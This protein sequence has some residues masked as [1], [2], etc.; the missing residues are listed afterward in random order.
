MN[1]ATPIVTGLHAA[2]VAVKGE[3]HR[4]QKAGDNTFDNY[5]FTSIDD[6]KDHVRPLLAKHG[7][8]LSISETSFKTIAQ[9][10]SKG[11]EKTHCEIGYEAWL[12]H[13]DGTE[14]KPVKSTVMLPYTGAQTT[15]IAE[16]YAIKKWAKSQLLASSG[17]ST[18][19]ADTRG[20]DE[21]VE[22]LS[23][24]EANPIFEALQKE[25][26]EIALERN[27]GSLMQWSTDNRS[28]YMSMPPD[29]RKYIKEEYSRTLTEIMA[30]EKLDGKQ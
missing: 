15:G 20:Q 18:E 22:V 6:F 17:D 19:E 13:Q 23:R 11:E 5:H 8:Y 12:T 2:I 25:L 27:S 21:Y 24:K 26:R 29:Y 7:L 9:K 14:T 28:L 30:N 10:N 16:S 3:I 1:D 4:L